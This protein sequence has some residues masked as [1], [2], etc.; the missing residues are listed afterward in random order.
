[1]T[2]EP[3][4]SAA[5]AL[6]EL[7]VQ[8][9]ELTLRDRLIL[10][11]GLASAG[12]D[13]GSL[14]RREADGNWR[15]CVERGRRGGRFETERAARRALENPLEPTL[16]G[17]AFVRVEVGP[18]GVALV[19]AGALD[20]D[21]EDALEALLTCMLIVELSSDDDH[22]QPEAP[23][24][25]ARGELGRLQHDVRNALTSL[26]ATRQVLER[27]GTDLASDER[28]AFHEA[29]HRECERTGSLLA[30]GILGRPNPRPLPAAAADILHDVV[31][32]E[33]AAL[34][35]AGCTATTSI[36]DE[37]QGLQPACGSAAWS[38]IVRNLVANAREAAQARGMA[39]A[40]TIRLEPAV[41]GLRL[42]VE[43]QGGGL[44]ASPLPRLFEE[45][46]TAGKP[47][48]SGQGLAVVRG[49]ALAS[50]GAVLVER[51]A[52]GARFEVWMPV[53]PGPDEP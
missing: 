51:R 3:A 44:P 28:Q 14:W 17:F 6:I 9:A 42:M 30:A 53:R 49:L 39:G 20:E 40:L 5:S 16:P 48:G 18:R 12:S 25:A 23:L 47:Q 21:A 38:R 2:H 13:S 10:E 43:D 50:A 35:R 31:K 34:E 45:G 26:M 11:A 15:C 27:F 22:P 36:A 7:L 8:S 33:Q 41:G 4:F 52:G 46:F 32:L 37:A 24:P 1:M 29:V 19:L